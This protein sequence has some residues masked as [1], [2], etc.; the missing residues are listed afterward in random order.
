[1]F[2]RGNNDRPGQSAVAVQITLDDGKDLAGKIQ[3][4]I[5]RGLFDQLNGGGG[6]VEFHTFDG[7]CSFVAKRTLRS[8]RELNVSKSDALDAKLSKAD[9]FDPYAI[10]GVRRDQTRQQIRAAYLK[11]SKR[12]H[13]DRYCNSELPEEVMSYLAAMARRVNAAYAAVEAA[14]APRSQ[15][16]ERYR[17][18]GAR[19]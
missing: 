15:P 13:P 9:S 6:F 3:V 12:Y 8:V 4:P 7:E 16:A 5:G 19:A 1:M 2:E 17:P 18:K 11:L 14:K 10:L